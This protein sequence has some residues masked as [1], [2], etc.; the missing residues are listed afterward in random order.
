M[1]DTLELLE[2]IG[3]D[4]T[5]RHASVDELTNIL[6]Q[7]QASEALKAAVASGNSAALFA[8]FGQPAYL[9]TQTIQTPGREDEE[10]E[11]EGEGEPEE[12]LA[13]DETY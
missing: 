12:S 9:S 5:L 11:E 1:T 4:A 3:Q 8:E 13:H 6:E 7:A 2:S 10:E